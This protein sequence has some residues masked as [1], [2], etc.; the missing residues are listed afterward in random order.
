MDVITN[1]YRQYLDG[2]EKAFDEI[3]KEYRYSLT[4]FI[5]SYIHDEASTPIFIG[6]VNNLKNN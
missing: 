5:N 1:K 2:D 3:L 4:L 6:V